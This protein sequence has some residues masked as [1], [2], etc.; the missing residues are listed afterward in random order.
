MKVFPSTLRG[1]IIM[2]FSAC[3]LFMALLIAINF[4]VLYLVVLIFLLGFVVFFIRGKIVRPLGRITQESENIA[5]GVFQG[6]ISPYGDP[7]N[8]IYSLMDA[9]NRMMNE[10]NH[11]QEL[12]VQSHKNAVIG[13]LS[14]GITHEINNPINNIVLTLETLIEDNQTLS[15]EERLQ[16][17]QE[18]LEEA[19]RAGDIVNNLLQFSRAH[20]PR[21]EEVSIEALIDQTIRLL[22]NEFKRHRI[23]TF[24]EI[25]GSFPTL[26][27]DKSGLQQVLVNLLL[28][29]VQAMPDGGQLRIILNRIKNEMQI[30][31]ADTGMGIPSDSLNRIFD[32][33]FTDKKGRAGLGLSI[34]Q[35]ILQKQGGRIKVQSIEGQGTTFSLMIPLLE[36]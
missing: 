21:V 34:S 4:R 11:R 20:P 17:Y 26:N 1:Q 22:K 18:T 27:L 30:D 28:N 29:S 14:P 33:F 15:P 31:I 10:L 3:F 5:Q 13:T 2:A 32:P 36:K 16:L 8:E 24:K 12:L 25:R 7:K 19:D 35:N 23:K 9:L 6:S